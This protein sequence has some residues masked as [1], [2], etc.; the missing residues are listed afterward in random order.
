MN[1]NEFITKLTGKYSGST[2]YDVE[3]IRR[4]AA[5]ININDK[6]LDDLYHYIAAQY[7][8]KTFPPLGKI[9]KI[10]NTTGTTIKEKFKY[11]EYQWAAIRRGEKMTL[12]SIKSK[13]L[14]V[15]D[16]DDPSSDDIDFIDAWDDLV[17]IYSILLERDYDAAR[18]VSYCDK[19][20]ESVIKGERLNVERVLFSFDANMPRRAVNIEGMTNG[21]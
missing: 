18:V 8:Y 2:K 13:I 16:H 15:R 12:K 5:S 17:T 10:W 6:Q 4:W 7:E 3:D 9:V 11:N 19:L 1:L 21:A 20:K 14:E